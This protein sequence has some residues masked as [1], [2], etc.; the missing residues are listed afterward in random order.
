MGLAAGRRRTESSVELWLRCAILR[1]P[2]FAGDGPARGH[3]PALSCRVRGATLAVATRGPPEAAELVRRL[4]TC[5]QASS[6]LVHAKGATIHG[7]RLTRKGTRWMS[8]LAC[9]ETEREVDT[10]P[11]QRGTL[12]APRF[13]VQAGTVADWAFLRGMQGRSGTWR[14]V[15]AEPSVVFCIRAAAETWL[16]V[17]VSVSHLGRPGFATC[18]GGAPPQPRRYRQKPSLQRQDSGVQGFFGVFFFV[19]VGQ[20]MAIIVV[21]T[22]RASHLLCWGGGECWLRRQPCWGRL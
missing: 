4:R 19:V 21:L 20:V 2:I 22:R 9:L 14:L 13:Y 7:A 5:L 1:I 10:V 11:R 15:E 8:S 16:R 6:Q 3:S 18:N 17:G 12:A